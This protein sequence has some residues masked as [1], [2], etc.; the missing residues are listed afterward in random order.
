MS[1]ISKNNKNNKKEILKRM[2]NNKQAIPA[3]NVSS[4]E[5]LRAIFEKAAELKYPV[6]IETSRWEADHLTPELLSA[7]CKDLWDRLKVEYILHLD[8]WNDL[9]FMKRCLDAWYDSISAE[10][11]LDVSYEENIELSKKA[12]ELTNKYSAILEWVME[13][14]PIVYYESN[15]HTHMDY[16]N[17]ELAKDFVEQVKPDI[18]CVSIWTQSWWLKNIKKI[19]WEPMEN[20]SKDMPDLP[21]ILHWWSFLD[22]D[23]I[24]KA[25]SL[26]VTKININSELRY[27]Y[28]NKLKENIKNNP[29]EY[30]PYRMLDWVIKELKK[31][32]ENKI[33]LM[34]N[35]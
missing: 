10:F 18:L 23:I 12:R 20:I 8:R 2:H 6:F 31:V 19:N 11:W 33:R 28:A 14:V 35:F 25:I 24:K 9:D 26:W 15:K 22:E 32:V 13:V 3:F 29:E 27:A 4:V 16:T 21:M 17:S 5:S 30:A 7:I 1:S 34:W